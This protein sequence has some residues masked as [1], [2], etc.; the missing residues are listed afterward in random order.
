MRTERCANSGSGGHAKAKHK[1]SHTA[2]CGQEC[3][4]RPQDLL[5]GVSEGFRLITASQQHNWARTMSGTID[6]ETTCNLAA[7]A[8]L[9]KGWRSDPAFHEARRS[10]REAI[11]AR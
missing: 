4:H 10:I 1:L 5:D 3:Q 9:L 7:T 11:V 8:I 6:H 2:D